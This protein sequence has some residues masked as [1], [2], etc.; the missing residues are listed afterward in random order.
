[1]SPAFDAGNGVFREMRQ[2]LE[3]LQRDL[4][5]YFAKHPEAVTDSSLM[6]TIL[7]LLETAARLQGALRSARAQLGADQAKANGKR[8]GRPRS[9]RIDEEGVLGDV[10]TGASIAAIGRAHGISRTTVRN[11]IKRQTG[12][13]TTDCHEML[14][15]VTV[16]IAHEREVVSRL[17]ADPELHSTRAIEGRLAQIA[18][19]ERL[20]GKLRVGGGSGVDGIRGPYRAKN[21]REVGL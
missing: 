13:T 7:Q 2:A 4:P 15:A 21:P 11:V 19:F 18:K 17:E 20:I 6:R 1:M 8:L 10:A 12:L 16:A 3:A 14:L 9:E 5:S